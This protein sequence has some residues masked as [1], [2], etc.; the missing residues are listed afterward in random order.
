MRCPNC[1]RQIT[2]EDA[3]FCP[4][5]AHPLG[6]SEGEATTPMAVPEA[7]DESSTEELRA[8]NGGQRGSDEA[9][10]KPEA[11]RRARRFGGAAA[12]GGDFAASMR[13]SVLRGGWLDV[14]GAA[15]LA[16][17][18]VLLVGAVLLLAI[19]LQAAGAGA[20]GDALD[21]FSAMV[22]LGLAAL[23]VPLH[24]GELELTVLPLGA[25]VV[26][27]AGIAWAAKLAVHRSAPEGLRD[28]AI[29]GAKVGVPFALI[30]WLAALAFQLRGTVDPV[31][32][33]AGGALLWGAFWGAGFGAL[34]GLTAR[35]GLREEIERGL[36]ALGRRSSVAAAGMV[37]GGVMLVA[38]AIL[39]SFAALVW[40]IVA[41][42]SGPRTDF[43]PAEA[44]AA[45]IYLAAFAPNVLVAIVA[46]AMGAPLQVGAAV[47]TGGRVVGPLTEISL[48]DWADGSAPWYLFLLLL[49]P[50]AA[51]AMGGFWVG[52]ARHPRS[53]RLGILLAGA[54]FFALVLGVLAAL[55]D[56]RLGAGLVRERGFGR[57]APDA[58]ITAG[59][60]FLWAAAAGFAGL[61]AAETGTLPGAKEE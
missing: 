8:T 28:A 18:V 47:T 16:F 55:G 22:V 51:C 44:A 48:L 29:Q 9:A 32:A 36:E 14:S 52:R 3:L 24:I 21:V 6:G 56:A 27:G 10:V 42:A 20:G 26:A 35:S 49:I 41:L 39:A 31:S 17:L 59:V 40:I 5:C 58:A 11:A 13:A 12:F 1:D 54:I 25:L 38:V 7:S 46:V 34:G 4:R 43:G 61:K 53:E 33:D 23:R 15:C 37:S 60:A 50:L 30:C 45:V 2:D 19:K 57:L